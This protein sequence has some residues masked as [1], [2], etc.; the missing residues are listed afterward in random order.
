MVIEHNKI[1]NTTETRLTHGQMRATAIYFTRAKIE[2][3]S[4]QTPDFFGQKYTEHL[5][6]SI[7]KLLELLTEK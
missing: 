2:L 6:S 5:Y 4:Q 7:A 1:E 3:Q